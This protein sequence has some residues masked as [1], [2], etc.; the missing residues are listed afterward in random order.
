[1]P[2]ICAPIATSMPQRSTIS[3]SR[4][5]LSMTVAPLA[6][7]AAVMM[8]SVAPTLGRVERDRGTAQVGGLG[9]DVTVLDADLGAHALET[10]EVHVERRVPIA[11]PP[12]SATFARPVRAMSGPR[13]QIDPR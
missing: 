8:F 13:T 11:S 3:G 6:S 12:G 4:A 7:T 10:G 5:A 9:D 2:S 1:M